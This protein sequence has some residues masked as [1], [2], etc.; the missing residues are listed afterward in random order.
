MWCEF[1]VINY[2]IADNKCVF[3]TCLTYKYILY[4]SFFL[5]IY[6]SIYLSLSLS[7][8]IYIYIYRERE[9]E[10]LPYPRG[11]EFSGEE[12]IVL[13]LATIASLF[14]DELRSRLPLNGCM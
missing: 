10:I 8:Y 7:L 14:V 9:R 11:V 3:C 1:S 13:P 4:I 5:S 6:L 2:D 12:V